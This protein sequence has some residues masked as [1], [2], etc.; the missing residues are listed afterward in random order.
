[1]TK[2]TY[3][4]NIEYKEAF[5]DFLRE[6]Q[7]T[8]Y[9]TI[10]FHAD[11]SANME[12]S[13]RTLRHFHNTIARHFLGHDSHKKPSDRRMQ[14]ISSPEGFRVG[15]RI[16]NQH[17][18]IMADLPS[19]GRRS[20]THAE[21]RQLVEDTWSALAPGGTVHVK[22]ILT[23]NDGL[24][25]AGYNAKTIWKGP[26]SL[27]VEHFV[28][29]PDC[30]GKA[31]QNVTTSGCSISAGPQPVVSIPAKDER[32]ASSMRA[33]GSSQPET[34]NSSRPGAG[35]SAV[36]STAAASLKCTY[37][38]P[39]AEDAV[40]CLPRSQS[41][42]DGD[43]GSEQLSAV[44]H[45]HDVPER[46]ISP[47][48]AFNHTVNN[49]DEDDELMVRNDLLIEEFPKGSQ[50]GLDAG[51]ESAAS[52]GPESAVAH[53]GT[54]QLIMVAETIRSCP[55]VPVL[56]NIPDKLRRLRRWCPWIYAVEPEPDG[57]F[58]QVPSVPATCRRTRRIQVRG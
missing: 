27:A 12:S 24:K 43:E 11:R 55:P 28:I 44:E 13:K 50:T 52:P 18:H 21:F 54:D 17:W 4:N 3:K 22:R 57:K 47:D 23:E 40:A 36:C 45:V 16:Y 1:M 35:G 38:S 15:P 53:Q 30:A 34:L 58:S 7:Y 33:C 25:I 42:P 2:T 9:I 41:L 8:Y 31:D 49:T 32:Q 37:E 14:S 48:V 46:D 29:S 56:E 51:G 5:A 6:R 10:S 20:L 26:D 39:G 19:G